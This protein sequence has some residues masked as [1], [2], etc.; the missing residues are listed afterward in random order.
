MSAVTSAL[1]RVLQ[2]GAQRERGGLQGRPHAKQN[3]RDEGYSRRERQNR[4]V[5]TERCALWKALGNQSS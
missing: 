5:Q 2:R 3:R 1:A 4:Q